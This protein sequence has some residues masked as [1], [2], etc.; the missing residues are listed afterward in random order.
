MVASLKPYQA[1]ARA[2]RKSGRESIALK[3]AI[4]PEATA[5]GEAR[6]HYVT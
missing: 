5:N 4:T 3:I 6:R 2:G 1:F